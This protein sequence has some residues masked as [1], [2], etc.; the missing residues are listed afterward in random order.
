M[1][2]ERQE[3]IGLST[4]RRKLELEHGAGTG[5]LK[6][7]LQEGKLLAPLLEAGYKPVT[8]THTSIRR[9]GCDTGSYIK[10]NIESHTDPELIWPMLL[11]CMVEMSATEPGAP[12][13]TCSPSFVAIF[14]LST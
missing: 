1:N 13:R 3:R 5:A 11:Y 8:G 14:N 2:R 10:I 6:E 9:R 7:V 4:E 12:S